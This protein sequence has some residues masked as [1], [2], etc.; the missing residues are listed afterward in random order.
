MTKKLMNLK[1]FI[2]LIFIA[3]LWVS[4]MVSW[5]SVTCG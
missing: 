4:V 3:E 1:L 5:Q 2:L